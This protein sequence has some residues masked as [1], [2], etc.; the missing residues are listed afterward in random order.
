MSK[1][2]YKRKRER[3]QQRL[4]QTSAK[5]KTLRKEEPPRP[6]KQKQRGAENQSGTSLRKIAIGAAS[7]ML[8][9]LGGVVAV[10]TLLP[11][12]SV[13][14]GDPIDPNDTLSA[15]FTISNNNFIQL[16]EVSAILWINEIQPLGVPLDKNIPADAPGGG[17]FLDDWGGHTLNMDD[18]YTISP[19]DA[20]HAITPREAAISIG[21]SYRPWILPWRL[22]RRFRFQTHRM[23]NG[24]LTW[25][26]LPTG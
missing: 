5:G 21:V 19:S 16:R 15:P 25:Y 8:A 26:Q 13:T 22:G 1:G 4:A 11:R 10:L 2:K 7:A 6:E 24:V 23:P 12:I 18:K 9:L 3:E 14:A 17:L 20:I